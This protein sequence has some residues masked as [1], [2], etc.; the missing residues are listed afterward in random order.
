MENTSKLTMREW[1]ESDQPREKLYRNGAG[2]LSDAELLAIILRSG[3]AEAT[4]LDL[5]KQILLSA[6]GSLA[7]L[8]KMRAA[9]IVDKFKG[10]GPAKAAS[11]LAALELGKRRNL[12]EMPARPHLNSSRKIYE[13]MFPKMAELQTEECW[14]LFLNVKNRLIDTVCISRGGVSD[15]SAEPRVVMREAVQRLASSVVLCHNHPSG[16]VEPSRDDDYMTKVMRSAAA[17]LGICLL[18]HLVIA[19]GKYYSYADNGRL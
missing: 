6:E 19:D 16:V 5:A 2:S 14:A 3:T 13:W 18:D 9:E 15:T 1:S 17:S 11:M 4:A 12:S 7:V 10:I 8:N